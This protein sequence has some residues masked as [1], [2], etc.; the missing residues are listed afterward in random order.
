MQKNGMET[1]GSC[2]GIFLA[3]F[4]VPFLFVA[5]L[6]AGYLGFL[7]FKVEI[8]TLITIGLIFVI[9][10][11][12]IRHNAAYSSCKIRHSF[13]WMEDQLQDELKA[14]ALT[15]MGKTKST[16]E[17]RDFTEEFFKDVRDDNYARVASSIFPML[18]SW[19][20]SLPLR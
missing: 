7:P 11:F 1:S 9:F 6:A 8:H 4:I 5:A 2:G 10:L 15:I 17:V 14:N 19:V 18:G 3:I 13:A 12:F 16:L 20:R